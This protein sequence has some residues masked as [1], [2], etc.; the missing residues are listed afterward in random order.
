MGCQWFA[1]KS[2]ARADGSWESFASIYH[3]SHIRSSRAKAAASAEFL[4]GAHPIW[5]DASEPQP[6]NSSIISACQNG[7]I[8]QVR[9]LLCEN[10]AHPNDRT[11]DNITVFR[12]RNQISFDQYVY[13]CTFKLTKNAEHTIQSGNVEVVQLV[14]DNGA[15][16]NFT[17]GELETYA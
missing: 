16:P 3:T 8:A 14:L 6:E 17:F 2:S 4:P 12:V 11:S 15:A 7:D 13:K 9:S 10:K 5:N 1:R